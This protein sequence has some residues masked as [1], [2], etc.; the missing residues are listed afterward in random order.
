MPPWPSLL[1]PKVMLRKLCLSEKRCARTAGSWHEIVRTC[2]IQIYP[3]TF[4]TKLS[5]RICPAPLRGAP[6][7]LG[8]FATKLRPRFFGS[9]LGWCSACF[10]RRS[11]F[12]SQ[13]FCAAGRCNFC[14]AFVFVAAA[15]CCVN[16]FSRRQIFAPQ[17]NAI[18][19][20]HFFS[21]AIFLRRRKYMQS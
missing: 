8:P 2:L 12:A 9:W 6:R 11:F 17:A 4:V 21:D 14:V 19:A 18:F 5:D 13:D 3:I 15:H 1:I 20:S 10:F 7:L 16:A